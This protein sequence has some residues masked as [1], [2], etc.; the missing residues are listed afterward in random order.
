[1]SDFFDLILQCVLTGVKDFQYKNL[2]YFKLFA[3]IDDG[4]EISVVRID[5]HVNYLYFF[6]HPL[7]YYII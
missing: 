4:S 1:M 7:N 5:H 2:S 3:Y 6:I